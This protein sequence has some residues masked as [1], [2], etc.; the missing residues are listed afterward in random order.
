MYPRVSIDAELRHCTVLYRSKEPAFPDFSK[1]DD[2]VGDVFFDVRVFLTSK[3]F[4]LTSPDSQM[5]S[6]LMA[7][8]L[9]AFAG[10]LP[11]ASISYMECPSWWVTVFR[12]E[13]TALSYYFI[14]FCIGRRLFNYLCSPYELAIDSGF[15]G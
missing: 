6:L 2:D 11:L 3:N 4:F 9:W 7:A 14:L 15:G 1:R 10:S 12:H 13:P 8:Q 5:Y